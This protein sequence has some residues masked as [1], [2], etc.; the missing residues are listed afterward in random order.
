MDIPMPIILFGAIGG[1]VLMGI[2]GLFIGAMVLAIGYTLFT[3]W[4]N[5]TAAES[6]GAADE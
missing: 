1:V 6:P 5:R 2:L 3:D 4:L